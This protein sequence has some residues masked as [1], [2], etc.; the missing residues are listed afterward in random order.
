MSIA[1][2]EGVFCN[3]EIA[4]KISWIILIFEFYLTQFACGKISA[5]TRD[6]DF[7][8]GRQKPYLRPINQVEHF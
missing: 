2:V 5:F 6:S 8:N 4:Q 3:A 1:L 7:L